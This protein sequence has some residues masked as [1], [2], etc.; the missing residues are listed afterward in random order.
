MQ[1]PP[2][3]AAAAGRP[4]VSLEEARTAA[5]TMAPG[6]APGPDGLPPIWKK[7][8]EPLLTVL[9]AVLSAVGQLQSS[10]DGFLDGCVTPI[11]KPLLEGTAVAHYRPITLLNTGLKGRRIGDNINDQSI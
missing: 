11:L 8:G 7:G 5:L 3:A 4:E 2:E 6:K 9:A 10:P 1:F